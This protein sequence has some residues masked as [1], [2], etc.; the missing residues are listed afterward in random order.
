[1]LAGAHN[2]NVPPVASRPEI[3]MPQLL[4]VILFLNSF[5]IL[6]LFPKP[7]GGYRIYE[8]GGHRI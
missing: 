6:L 5:K 8:R 4:A 1:M 7:R 3:I 2:E